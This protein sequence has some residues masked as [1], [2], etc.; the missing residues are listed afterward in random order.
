M[1][2]KKIFHKYIKTEIDVFEDYVW[3][4]IIEIPFDES[5]VISTIR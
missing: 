5:Q 2:E 4:S 1:P 3:K